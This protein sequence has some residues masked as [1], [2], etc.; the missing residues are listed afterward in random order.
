MGTLYWAPDTKFSQP[1]AIMVLSNDLA[2]ADARRLFQREAQMVPSP[3]YPH[4]LTVH[5]NGEF[6]GRR[7]QTDLCRSDGGHRTFLGTNRTPR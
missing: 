6:E 4:I 2:D 5:D 3:R 1:V 7:L